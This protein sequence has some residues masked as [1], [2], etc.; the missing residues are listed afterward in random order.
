[1]LMAKILVFLPPVAATVTAQAMSPREGLKSILT[2]L[3][4]VLVFLGTW[5]LTR[6]FLKKKEPDEKDAELAMTPVKSK[7]AKSKSPDEMADVIVRLCADQFT[8]GLRMYREMVKADQDKLVTG[9]HFFMSLVE[10]SVR[11]GKPDVALQVLE[12]MRANG[13][14]PTPAFVESVLKLF[15]ARKLHP[16]C[17][18]VWTM[19]G[20]QLPPHQ[21]ILSCVAVAACEVGK[22]ELG[23]DLLERARRQFTMP[24]REWL[25]VMRHYVREKD[26]QR[27][28]ADMKALVAHEMPI[29][30]ILFN[31]VMAVCASCEEAVEAMPGLLEEM[32]QYQ[33]KFPAA[34]PTVDIVT[35]NTLLK[36]F[37]RRG[38]VKACFELFEAVSQSGLE[39]DDVSFSTLLDVCIDEDEHQ[40]ASVAL[41]RMATHGVQMNTIVMTTL[42]KGFVRTKR[43]DK[44]MQLYDSM[45]ASAS[46]IKPDMI[47]H[48]MLIKAHCDAHDMSNALKVLEDMLES[49]C[50]VDDVVFTILIEGCCQVNNIRL[51]EKLFKDMI[52][53]KIQP[54]IY[55]LN[56]LVKIYGKS[57]QSH[58][59]VNLVTKMEADFG[60]K[61]TIVVYTCL[62]S[63]L[64]RTK[65]FKEAWQIWQSMT[66]NLTPDLHG[67][68][69]MI[70]GLV[71]GS[72]WTE[73]ITL[74]TEYVA[75]ASVHRSLKQN[76]AARLECL[77]QALSTTL[78]RGQ[79]EVARQLY[80]VLTDNGCEVTV[81][82]A[83][84]RLNIQ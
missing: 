24:S 25:A 28:V 17:V 81:A 20:E 33:V 11:V 84:S 1:M 52:A 43:L 15:A 5:S 39:P 71:D 77:N 37:G 32:K 49:D 13:N 27:A 36:A 16:Q 50:P 29:D 76:R 63:G 48:S 22:V 18:D 6:L 70:G 34:E 53:A 67:Y 14:M 51:A 60:I 75:F 9:D 82:Q 73:L 80:K 38:D 21:V 62:M 45:R 31:T 61:P 58:L 42:M 65:K 57:S 79:V 35:Y 41:E 10:A 64:I 59:A 47:T 3:V 78:N 2:E 4:V 26:W 46:A 23:R 19:F 83:K 44:A 74:A 40:L 55:T 30:N 69:T 8:R 7:K 66:A 12:R 68:Q 72:M 56:G 54:S